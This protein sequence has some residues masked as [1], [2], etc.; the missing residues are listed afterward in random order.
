MQ[1][2]Q[3]FKVRSLCYLGEAGQ[4]GL[5]PIKVGHSTVRKEPTWPSQALLRR[6]TPATPAPSPTEQGGGSFVL[7][8]PAS[9]GPSPPPE[10]K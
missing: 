7:P 9:G 8:V 6:D 5:V 4:R 1:G 2:G 3:L 10:P